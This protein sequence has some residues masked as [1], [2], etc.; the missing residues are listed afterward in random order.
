LRIDI[1]KD[2]VLPESRRVEGIRY[3]LTDRADWMDMTPIHKLVNESMKS[4]K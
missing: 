3:I 2:H 1:P 4:G